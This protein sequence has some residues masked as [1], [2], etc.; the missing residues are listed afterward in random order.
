MTALD[1]LREDQ[2]A[3][4]MSVR[5]YELE[6]GVHLSSGDGLAMGRA[7]DIRDHEVRMSDSPNLGRQ[8]HCPG[9]E[10]RMRPAP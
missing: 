2:K 4:G 1:W 10:R 8:P 6:Y 7:A 9:C 5:E 3:S